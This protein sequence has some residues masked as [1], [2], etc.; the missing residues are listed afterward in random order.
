MRTG[1]L[2]L[3]YTAID[4]AS[5][6]TPALLGGEVRRRPYVDL[7]LNREYISTLLGVYC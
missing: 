6:P 3:N 4:G 5:T 1:A 7:L 2:L